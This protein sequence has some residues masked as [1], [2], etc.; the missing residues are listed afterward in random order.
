[1]ED[2]FIIRTYEKKL[3]AIEKELNLYK[4]SV[5]AANVGVWQWNVETG[6]QSIN[7]KW[8]E[9][10]GYTVEELTPISIET[11]RCLVHPEDLRSAEVKLRE[12]IANSVAQ[13]SIEF[14]MKHKKGHW[15][16]IESTGAVTSW[17]SAGKAIVINGSHIDI[18][19][20]KIAEA[21]IIGS[22]KRL[23]ASQEIS[24][25]GNWE[26]DLETKEAYV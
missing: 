9:I 13:Y 22:E 2:S 19:D 24:H 1:M 21:A 20:R 17:T 10:I 3:L 8:A 12:I 16:W 18:T 25:V 14:R 26:I 23:N 6:D 15:I 5:T 11:W 4:Y 7:E